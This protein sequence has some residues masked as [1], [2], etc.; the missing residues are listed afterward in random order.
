MPADDRLKCP[1]DGTTMDKVNAAGAIIDRC[2]LCGAIWFDASEL[3]K[4]LADK[5]ARAAIDAGGADKTSR[6]S[7]GRL[8]PG[9]GPRNLQCPRDSEPL[10]TVPDQSQ[11]HI[12]VDRCSTC[13]GVLL[14]AGELKDMAEFRL[15]ERLGNFSRS[16]L[17]FTP[18]LRISLTLLYFRVGRIRRIVYST[19]YD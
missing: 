5:A 14:D 13:L 7:T 12:Q 10:K 18:L 6:A 3:K 8:G 17:K 1:K 11:V 2:G 19:Q 15:G 9:R 16:K 4:V